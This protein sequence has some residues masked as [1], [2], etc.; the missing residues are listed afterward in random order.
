M[1]RLA[2]SSWKT[3]GVG[4]PGSA[5]MNKRDRQNQRK[6][7]RELVN[8]MEGKSS[9]SKDSKIKL[10]H[11]DVLHLDSHS[12]RVTAGGFKSLLATGFQVH[13]QTNDLLHQVFNFQPRQEKIHL[14]QLEKKMLFS[15]N[16]TAKKKQTKVRNKDR[17]V[18][19]TALDFYQEDL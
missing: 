15:P 16:S 19:G 18:K 3:E 14:S 6:A 8:A 10:K 17:M 2:N 13:M 11:G 1:S 4:T 5:R 12:L 9:S 7:F